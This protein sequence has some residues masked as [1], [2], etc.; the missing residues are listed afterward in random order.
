MKTCT[1]WS[2][3]AHLHTQQHQTHTGSHGRGLNYARVNCRVMFNSSQ[4]TREFNKKTLTPSKARA[5]M[6]S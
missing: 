2:L 4:I 3:A 1:D 6:T 5:V